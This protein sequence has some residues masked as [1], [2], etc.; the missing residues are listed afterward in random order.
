MAE[1]PTKRI[2]LVKSTKSAGAEP[3]VNRLIR[4]ESASKAL[5]HVVDGYFE[6]SLA[7]QDQCI[8]L[9]AAGVK[10]EDAKNGDGA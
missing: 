1:T 6:V 8:E 7:S 3:P 4:A 9:A 2:Y 5:R 10:P